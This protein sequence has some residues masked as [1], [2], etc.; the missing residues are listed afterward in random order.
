MLGRPV[1]GAVHA[2][3][4]EELVTGDHRPTTVAR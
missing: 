2:I 4:A 1:Y 3:V